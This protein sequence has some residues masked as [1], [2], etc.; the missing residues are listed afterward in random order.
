MPYTDNV[1]LEA[2]YTSPQVGNSF[3]YAT[4]D[5]TDSFP[6]A[7]QIQVRWEVVTVEDTNGNPV[8]TS[9]L[10]SFVREQV[11]S[12]DSSY[13]TFDDSANSV[14]V[15]ASAISGATV[16]VTDE[17]GNTED[18]V[19]GN[20]SLINNANPVKVRRSIN[21]TD[22]VID[23]QSGSRL[24]AAQLNAAV[25]Q[26]LYASQELTQF[27]SGESADSS[28]NLSGQ[29]INNLGDVNI[30]LTNPGALLVVDANGNI[31]DS[32]TGGTNEVLSVNGNTGFVV[33]S[34]TD[35]G[36]APT[37]HSHTTADITDFYTN[38]YTVGQ[39]SDV[40]LSNITLDEGDVV[41][42]NPTGTKWEG[43]QIIDIESGT[44]TPPSSWTTAAHRKPGD[45][46]IRYGS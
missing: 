43:R 41:S 18:Y 19:Y 10:S 17:S 3:S 9:Q 37:V 14:V 28:V 35:V 5:T 36:A 6:D 29:S 25:E 42:Y 13:L 1:T 12:V 26:L 39:L 23:F 15:D 38:A 7:N 20:F 11:W 30:N 24:T 46:F 2:V 45:L 4:V 44:G 33:L 32:T 31:T 34:Y 8:Q 40:D 16:T 27:G 21:L 22:S